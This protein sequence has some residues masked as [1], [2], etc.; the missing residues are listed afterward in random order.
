METRIIIKAD[1]FRDFCVKLKPVFSLDTET[2]SLKWLDLEMLGFSISDGV[3]GCYVDLSEENRERMLS[4]LEYYISQAK[5]IIMHN[6]PYDMMALRK[7]GI[8]IVTGNDT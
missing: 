8:E 6:S 3:Q 4:I 7:V 2:S 1:E 5:I